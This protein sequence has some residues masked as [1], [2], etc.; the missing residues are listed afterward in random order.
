M[1]CFL[2]MDGVLVDFFGPFVKKFGGSLQEALK[3]NELPISVR[4]EDHINVPEGYNIYDHWEMEDW[5]ALKP[6]PWMK[7]LIAYVED[8]FGPENVYLCT[9]AG[10]AG[11]KFYEEAC[12]GKSRW[13]A[14]YLPDYT[15]RLIICFSKKAL[16]HPDAVLIDDQAGNFVSFLSAGGKA[17]LFPAYWNEAYRV[18]DGTGDPGRVMTY[19]KQKVRFVK[20]ANCCP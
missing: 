7:E 18:L 9:S 1:N 17:I 12:K 10:Y 19:I 16:A 8:Q 2:D 5:L 14:E 11:T 6:L 13:V 15:K 4:L 3:K 20:K